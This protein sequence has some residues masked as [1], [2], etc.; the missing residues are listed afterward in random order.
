MDAPLGRAIGNSLEIIE[1]LDTLKGNGPSDLTL[2]VKRLAAR[3]VVLAGLADD[4]HA[5][6]DRVEQALGS[7]R[8]LET[9]AR[10]VERQGG[11]PR[12]ADDYSLL[13]SA[14]GRT[15]C[16]APRGG[17][18]TALKAEALGRASNVLGAG[19][20]M[21]GDSVD[22]GVGVVVLAKP[23]DRVSEGQPLV[24]L[25][26]RDGRGL[27]AALELCRAGIRIGDAPPAQRDKILGEV[28]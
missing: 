13:P 4:E 9:F 20:T 23:G 2:V 24:E 11:N 22:H 19:R 1:C 8:A 12:V 26:H 21:V 16:P 17:Y 27:D 14:P 25:H 18:L 3:M 28:R 7:G 5:A 6:G 15:A 10:M